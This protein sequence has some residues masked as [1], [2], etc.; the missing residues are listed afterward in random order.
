[1]RRL[2]IVLPMLLIISGCE[3]EAEE[4]TPE[5]ILTGTWKAT[6]M[7][8]FENSDCTGS[9]DYTEWS[10]AQSFG[11][12]M[13]FTFNDDATVDIAVTIF[14]IP[15]SETLSWTATED[16]LC[17]D[18]ECISYSLSDDNETLTFVHSEDAYCEDMDG[19]EVDMNETECGTA[20][21]DWFDEACYEYT[22]TKQ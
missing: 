15:D 17:I 1:M 3:E 11:L 4:Q 16:Q 5:D 18:G 19:N 7:G 2:L 20:G 9:L 12:T 10:F 22:V 13:S 8:V 21:N 6:N 14:G